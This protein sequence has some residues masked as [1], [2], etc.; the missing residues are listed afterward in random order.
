MD[1]TGLDI[2]TCTDE[3]WSV[4]NHSWFLAQTHV[5]TF[6]LHFCGRRLLYI[7]FLKG[8]VKSFLFPKWFEIPNKRR[9]KFSI[10]LRNIVQLRVLQYHDDVG[11]NMTDQI[12]TSKK[13]HPVSIFITNVALCTKLRVCHASMK[14]SN[15][16]NYIDLL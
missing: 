12:R 5:N 2:V 6:V 8:W 15:S 16:L 13:C 11:I 7:C 4:I 3:M 14:A 9:N 1:E 10:A